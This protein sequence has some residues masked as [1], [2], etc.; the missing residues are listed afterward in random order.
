MPKIGRMTKRQTELELSAIEEQIIN[1]YFQQDVENYDDLRWMRFPLKEALQQ[2]NYSQGT[3]PR[4]DT[5]HVPCRNLRDV[6]Y[7]HGD[8]YNYWAV[9]PQCISPECRSFGAGPI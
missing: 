1:A 9:C 2:R 6:Y 8:C 3:L 7:E 5:C 4:C